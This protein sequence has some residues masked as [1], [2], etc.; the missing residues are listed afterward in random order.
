MQQFSEFLLS[1]LQEVTV[2]NIKSEPEDARQEQSSSVEQPASFESDVKEEPE[3]VG[4]SCEL[5]HAKCPKEEAEG[6]AL[7]EKLCDKI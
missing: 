5:G 3:E 7:C 1:L 2:P 6:E 4:E